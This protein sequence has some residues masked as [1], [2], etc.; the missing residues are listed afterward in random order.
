M[1]RQPAAPAKPTGGDDDDDD[2]GTEP[3][4]AAA[5]RKSRGK[6]TCACTPA[7]AAYMAPGVLALGPILCGACEQLFEVRD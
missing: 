4:P 5:R 1:G 7:R 3:A 6:V 2:K